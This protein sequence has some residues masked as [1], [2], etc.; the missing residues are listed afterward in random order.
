MRKRIVD[1]EK[2][3]SAAQIALTSLTSTPSPKTISA[4][5]SSLYSRRPLKERIITAV[6][7]C[8]RGVELLDAPGTKTENDDTLS[9]TQWN[10][11]WS[12]WSFADDL[13]SDDTAA[14]VS[15]D[16]SPV[17]CN[18]FCCLVQSGFS[19]KVA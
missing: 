18:V 5:K 19:A 8:T 3:Q 9:G 17:R 13:P 14:L 16:D 7:A 11:R 1:Y 4:W 15:E 10:P 2:L 6:P 12:T